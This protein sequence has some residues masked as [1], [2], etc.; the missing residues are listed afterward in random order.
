MWNVY[1][2][3]IDRLTVHSEDSTYENEQ[4]PTGA[5]TA[6]QIGFATLM[7]IMLTSF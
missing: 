7:A 5:L 2:R 3:M 4:C 1:V 6:V